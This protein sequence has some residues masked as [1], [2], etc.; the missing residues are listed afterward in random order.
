MIELIAIDVDGCL[1]DGSIIYTDSGDEIKSFN[2]K[3]GL[4]IASW[5]KLG[6]KIA[7]ITGRKSSVVEKRAK[8]LGI[9]HLYQS[10]SNKDEV[11]K[12]ILKK[13]NLE[14]SQVAA[15]G[16]DLNDYKMLSIVELSFAPAD[17]S[18]LINDVVEVS[19]NRV[20][21]KGAVKEMIEYIVRKQNL[22]SEY[23]N[24]WR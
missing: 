6:K 20:G 5:I 17:C 22:E 13:E 9:Q 21:G 24:L 12:E 4:A 1:T 3:D 7:I 16:D 23:L 2:V 11:L 15:I 19:L 18:N 8:E 10:V 14:L